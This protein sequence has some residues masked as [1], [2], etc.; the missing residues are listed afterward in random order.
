MH[1]PGHAVLNL[2]VLGEGEEP[3]TDLAVL[4]GALVPDLPMVGFYLWARLGANLPEHV[5]WSE[6]YFDPGWQTFFDLFNS[7]PLAVLL[8][9]FAH[10]LA[11]PRTVAFGWSLLL[12]F[13]L[14]FPLHG[15]DAHRHFFPLSD[16]RFESPLSYW[17]PSAGGALVGG[18]EIAV[19]ASL[20]VF[21]LL[22]RYDSWWWRDGLVT[23]VAYYA[24]MG[25]WAARVWS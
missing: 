22:R 11:M 12:H 6:T 9:V 24:A 7:A 25:W 20:V 5:I 21:V 23:A 4:A 1:T 13:A 8:L 14:D 10:R 3:R 2:A 16:Y 17:D 19:V 18:V 15:S